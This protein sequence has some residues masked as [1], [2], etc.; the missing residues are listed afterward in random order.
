LAAEY[1]KS[2]ARRVVDVMSAD[3]VNVTELATFGEAARTKALKV[4]VER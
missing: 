3:V 2:H 4:I 1:I